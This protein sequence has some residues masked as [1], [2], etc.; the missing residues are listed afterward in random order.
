MVT[1]TTF[2]TQLQ[3]LRS[4]I[5]TDISNIQ[6]KQTQMMDKFKRDLKV[7]QICREAILFSSQNLIG[8]SQMTWTNL[9]P[10][11]PVFSCPR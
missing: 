7:I 4:E 9:F 11:C 10:P 3:A 6:E 1:M 2:Q 8:A 5:K